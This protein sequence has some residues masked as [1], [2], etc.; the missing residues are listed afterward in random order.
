MTSVADADQLRLGRPHSLRHIE[1]SCS[2]NYKGILI[3]PK[4]GWYDSKSLSIY[5]DLSP[6]VLCPDQHTFSQG[7]YVHFAQ[8][9]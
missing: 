5:C 4:D 9:V 7:R 6:T 8:R 1:S 2:A 3:F